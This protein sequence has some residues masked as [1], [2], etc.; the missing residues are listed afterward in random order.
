MTRWIQPTEALAEALDMAMIPLPVSD[1]TADALESGEVDLVA[2]TNDLH[3]HIAGAD[4]A[5]PTVPALRRCAAALALAAAS[6]ASED[7]QYTRASELLQIA[8]AHAPDDTGI[9]AS[10]GSALWMSGRRFH[11]L[12]QLARAVALNSEQGRIVPMLWV[13]TARAMADAGRHGDA[14]LLLEELAIDGPTYFPF[15]ELMDSIDDRGAAVEGGYRP[16]LAEQFVERLAT[17]TSAATTDAVALA[18]IEALGIAPAQPTPAPAMCLE[19]SASPLPR[20]EGTSRPGTLRTLGADI[21]VVRSDARPAPTAGQSTLQIELTTPNA[22]SAALVALDPSGPGRSDP[23]EAALEATAGCLAA[24]PAD[25]TV[26]SDPFQHD[27][28]AGASLALAALLDVIH[29]A[30]EL[31]VPATALPLQAV[32]DHACGSGAESMRDR[33]RQLLDILPAPDLVHMGLASLA[34]RGFVRLDSN[35]VHP[36]RY[37]EFLTSGFGVA[38]RWWR[39]T[40][41]H[42]HAR[43]LSRRHFLSA[44]PGVL[45][46]GPTGDGGVSWRITDRSELRRELG[47]ELAIVS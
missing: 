5:D 9:R 20:D 21:A 22:S 7:D 8:V 30:T 3:G 36:E 31:E 37:L 35:T 4:A 10:Y 19:I 42:T 39:F 26:E 11:G 46:L 27:L 43:S 6:A 12:A 1:S 16:D 25:P 41:H 23:I 34:E 14:L 47:V 33:V 29:T 18:A 24:F 28:D 2:L 17:A 45:R 15:W 40:H 32:V 13:F 44:G 38:M